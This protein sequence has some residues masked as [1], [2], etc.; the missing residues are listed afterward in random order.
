MSTA[1]NLT[2]LNPELITPAYWSNIDIGNPG[3]FTDVFPTSPEL[4]GSELK[5]AFTSLYRCLS[6]ALAGDA[7]DQAYFENTLFDPHDDRFAD[8]SVFILETENLT[9]APDK[10]I[11]KLLSIIMDDALEVGS[12]NGMNATLV[13][14][15]RQLVESRT[16]IFGVEAATETEKGLIYT[17][18][19]GWGG[20][21]NTKIWCKEPCYVGF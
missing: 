11:R 20:T 5:F 9:F 17:K 18:K 2:T 21:C 14:S 3:H 19:L 4:R 12:V 16:N 13:D 10:R 8:G 15:W 6:N 1:K 7:T